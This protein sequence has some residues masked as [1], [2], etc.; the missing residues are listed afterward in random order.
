MEKIKK[1]GCLCGATRYEVNLDDYQTGNCHCTM[2]QKSGGAPYQT[3]TSVPEKNFKW[4]AAPQGRVQSGESSWRLFCRECGS[5]LTFV[6][7]GEE[8]HVIFTTATLDEPCGV[9]P[10][11]EI[12]TRSRLQG[13]LPVIGAKQFDGGDVF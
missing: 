9:I 2:C 4:R 10:S 11:Y 8:G 13:V 3:F 5:P 7:K 6:S 12:Y 1:G